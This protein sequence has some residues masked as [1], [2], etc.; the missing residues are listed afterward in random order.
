MSLKTLASDQIT[1]AALLFEVS[2]H[3]FF[4]RQP[5]L[6]EMSR[7]VYAVVWHFYDQTSDVWESN[8]VSAAWIF[9]SLREANLRVIHEAVVD[10][11]ILDPE[12]IENLDRDLSQEDEWIYDGGD[13]GWIRHTDG[14]L[15]VMR[16]LDA[17]EGNR[18]FVTKSALEE[19]AAEYSSNAKGGEKPVKDGEEESNRPDAAI[20]QKRGAPMQDDLAGVQDASKKSRS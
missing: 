8:E 18:I 13:E 14:M 9:T 5:P 3:P 11:G 19:G 17:T 4:E 7:T 15:D 1:K 20:G 12:E 16:S 10:E 2:S 6:C